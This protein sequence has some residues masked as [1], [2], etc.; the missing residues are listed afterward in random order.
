MAVREADF[1]KFARDMR[2]AGLAVPTTAHTKNQERCP[3]PTTSQMRVLAATKVYS[4]KPAGSS[5]G[6]TP[7]LKK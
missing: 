1:H 7:L 3:T 2:E 6:Y 4:D 5:A